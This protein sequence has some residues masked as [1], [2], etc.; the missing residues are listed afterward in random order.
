M[1]ASV[2]KERWGKGVEGSGREANGKP[3]GSRR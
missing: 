2:K 3:K 1:F